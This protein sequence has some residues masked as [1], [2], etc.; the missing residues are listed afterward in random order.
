MGKI[1]IVRQAQQPSKSQLRLPLGI[2]KKVPTNL[3]KIHLDALVEE[4]IKTEIDEDES[5]EKAQIEEEAVAKRAATKSIYRNLIAS[6]KKKI[7][8]EHNSKT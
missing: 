6:L 8:D 4:Y 7:R 1:P 3:R 5:Y 2:V